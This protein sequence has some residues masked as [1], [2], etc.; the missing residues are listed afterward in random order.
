MLTLHNIHD[1]KYDCKLKPCKVILVISGETYNHPVTFQSIV[2]TFK[3]L[4]WSIINCIEKC[5]TRKFNIFQYTIISN[6][7]NIE[8]IWEK[9]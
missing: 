3:T 7:V 4:I 8:K 2:K 9:L 1:H 6:I 5:K